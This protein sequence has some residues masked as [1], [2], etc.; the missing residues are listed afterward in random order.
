MSFIIS[1]FLLGHGSFGQVYLANDE[2]GKKYAVKCCDID[3][4]GIPNI[5]EASI[6]GSIIHPYLNRALRIQA[7]DTK[8]YIIQPLAETDL[9]QHT[10]KSKGGQTPTLEELRVWAFRLTHAVY[11]LHTEHIIHA[12]IKGS[13]VLLYHDGAICLTDFTLAVKKWNP[14]ETFSHNVCTCTH[15]PLENLLRKPWNEAL[16]IWS[17]GCT[18]YEIA[19]GE[20]LFPY[21]GELEPDPKL[22]DKNAKIRLRHRSINAILDWALQGPNPIASQDLLGCK[23]INIDYLPPKLCDNFKRPEMSV[24]NNLVCSM[25]NVEANK[26][27]TIH[28]ILRHPFFNGLKAPMYMSIIR[29]INKISL[30]EQARVTRYIQRYSKDPNVQTLAFNIYCRCNDL[31][32]ISE[33]IKAASC[34]WI[35]SKI[36]LDRPPHITLPLHQI[37]STEREI[38]H[39]LNFRLHTF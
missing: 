23:K 9:A 2:K 4:H 12:D 14:T 17:L 24:F 5:L 16:D 13:N 1:D 21:Q 15:R 3:A 33:T 30:S 28:D 39:N 22:K 6:M 27:P 38:C 34:T 32:T 20:L 18:F 37:L 25:L 26:R 29:P 7:S 31:T 10:R 8:L 35:A 36:V 19:Y 11:T